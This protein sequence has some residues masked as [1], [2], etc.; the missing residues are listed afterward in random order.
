VTFGRLASGGGG[1]LMRMRADEL[2]NMEANRAGVAGTYVAWL[3]TNS[4]NAIDV[5]VP[6]NGPWFL[7]GADGARVFADRAAVT[8]AKLDHFLD[9]HADGTAAMQQVEVYTGTR[10]NGSTAQNECRDWT[11]ID[12][13][14]EGQTGR[15]AANTDGKWTEDAVITC[16]KQR[17]VV[18]FEK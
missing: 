1:N 16:E 4:A 9:R 5:L 12:G 8:S 7:P 11:T 2:C 15:P 10:A 3:S 13:S 17:A 6:A 18:C 14:N